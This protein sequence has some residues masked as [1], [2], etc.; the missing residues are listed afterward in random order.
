MANAI[1]IENLTKEY[2]T[3]FG[4]FRSVRRA[5]DRLT[6]NVAPGECM[7]FLGAN[8]AG[9]STTIKV[10]VGLVFP[11]SGRV[12]IMGR[13]AQ[14][15]LARRSL[16]YLPEQPNFYDHLT[17]LELVEMTARLQGMDGKSARRSAE[18]SLARARLASEHW[19]RRL[20]HFSKGMLQRVGLAQALLG[21]P[22]II[23]LDEPMS[24]LDPIGRRDV[25]DIINDLRARGATV[26]FSTHI[27]ADAEALAD[28]VCVIE[29]GSLKFL[30]TTS[31]LQLRVA[32]S[33]PMEVVFAAEDA[34]GLSA[35]LRSAGYA[36]TEMAT[37]VRLRVAS[38]ADV[39][40]VL[41]L[42]RTK[43]ARLIS[44]HQAS[45]SLEALFEEER[46]PQGRSHVAS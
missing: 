1:D 20:R 25:R 46:Q 22:E 40:A 13:D 2:A 26:F 15:A 5:L 7:A 36:V 18:D 11:T 9:K 3:G 32:R 43:H 33:V 42:A 38:E 41:A 39:D 30:G 23:I 28:R 4:P 45:S 35:A 27:L 19:D 17:A 31:D 24:G 8:G 34:K 12:R 10:I 44:I 37:S 16:G 21:D 6:L 14:D 29:R